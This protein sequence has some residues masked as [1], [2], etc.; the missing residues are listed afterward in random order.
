M[1]FGSTKLPFPSGV[2]GGG[3]AVDAVVMGEVAGL[4]R[5]DEDSDDDVRG[6]DKLLLLLLLL[7]DAVVEVVKLPLVLMS[8]ELS[9]TSKS[10]RVGVARNLLGALESGMGLTRFL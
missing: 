5:D 3:V 8:S 1:K 7:L 9:A 4:P 6:A 10:G 2:G